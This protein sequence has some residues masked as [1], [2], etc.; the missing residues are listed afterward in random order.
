MQQILP[1]A[2]NSSLH[3]PLSFVVFLYLSFLSKGRMKQTR[4][5]LQFSLF[6]PLVDN[7]LLMIPL[8]PVRNADI[9]VSPPKP[10]LAGRLIESSLGTNVVFCCSSPPLSDPTWIVRLCRC[11]GLLPRQPLFLPIERSPVTFLHFLYS[12]SLSPQFPPL[13]I[14]NL[15]PAAKALHICP[16]G[17]IFFTRLTMIKKNVVS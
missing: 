6:N 2:A 15:T 10:L 4:Q 12:Y 14:R 3:P 9:S 5:T 8:V 13:A 1:K 11:Q 7:A 17:P 16:P